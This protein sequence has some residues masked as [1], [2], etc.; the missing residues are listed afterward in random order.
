MS[1]HELKTHPEYFQKSIDGIKD[2]E[3]RINDR[4]FQVGDEIVLK[5]FD[6]QMKYTGR[7]IYGHIT[8]ILSDFIGLA[9][10][11]VAFSF[12]ITHEFDC[13]QM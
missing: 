7:E 11:Y 12:S 3:I 13:E 9:E 2:F 6:Y 1:I 10:N 8:Y 4:N 5:E